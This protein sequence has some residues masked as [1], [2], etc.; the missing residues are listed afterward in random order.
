MAT[1]QKGKGTR[2]RPVHPRTETEA[3]EEEVFDSSLHTDRAHHD[4]LGRT[5]E[6]AERDESPTEAPPSPREQAAIPIDVTN[7]DE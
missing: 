3:I 7:I 6:P 5:A 1:T 2:K 4:E